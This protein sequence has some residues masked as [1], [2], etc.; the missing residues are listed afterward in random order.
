[1]IPDKWDL[2]RAAGCREMSDDEYDRHWESTR[3]RPRVSTRVSGRRWASFGSC[4]IPYQLGGKHQTS[5]W[6]HV[7]DFDEDGY[8]IKSDWHLFDEPDGVVNVAQ[9]LCAAGSFA[10]D[11]RVSLW[12]WD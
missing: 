1:M 12:G 8:E 7:K 6:I 4:G 10:N 11:V 3:M 9:G 5:Y 2:L